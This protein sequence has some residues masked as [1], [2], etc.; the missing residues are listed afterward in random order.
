MR[1]HPGEIFAYNKRIINLNFEREKHQ[2]IYGK[3]FADCQRRFPLWPLN[4]QLMNGEYVWLNAVLCIFE[5]MMGVLKFELPLV[6]VSMQPL[7]DYDYDA[8]IRSVDNKWKVLPNCSEPTIKNLRNAYIQ[9]ITSQVPISIVAHENMLPAIYDTFKIIR[10]ICIFIPCDIPVLTITN[11]SVG[12]W[13]LLIMVLY[14]NVFRSR[15]FRKTSSIF[16]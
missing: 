1:V 14:M 13:I 7:K 11:T 8:Y 6:N 16:W 5:N 9:A 10:A 15:K 2:E 12:V 3:T 4:I